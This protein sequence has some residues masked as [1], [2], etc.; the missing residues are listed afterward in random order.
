M[1]KRNIDQ[2]FSSQVSRSEP[3][4]RLNDGARVAVIGGGPAGSFFSYFLLDMAERIRLDVEVDIYEPRDFSRPAPYG[5]N[6]CGGVVSESLVQYLA[7]EGINLPPTVVQRG[8]DSYMMH[9][10]VGSK[11][12]ETPLHEK[13]I[14]A[15]HRGG[16]PR[17]IQTKKWDSFDGYLLNLA[18]EKGAQVLR[19][20]V[21]SVKW[22]NGR[23]HI[24][25]GKEESQAYD[26]V[27]VSSGVNA[28]IFRRLGDTAPHYKPPQT[29]K[30]AIREYHLGME[31]IAE[32]FGSSF[33]V[34]L[35]DLPR[36]EFAAIIPKGDYVTVILL[37]EAIDNEL[38]GSFL[39][40]PP[41][42]NRFPPDWQW[43]DLACNCS[44]RINTRGSAKPYSDRIVFI[45]DCGVTRLYKDGIG[46]AYRTAKAAAATAV[47]EGVSAQDFRQHF[48]RA[49]R[50]IERDNNIGK[51]IF[52]IV[53]LIQKMPFARHGLLRM[54]AKEQ[55]HQDSAKPMSSV[56]WDTFTGS[57]AYLDI[58]MRTLHPRFL[59]S[60]LGHIASVFVQPQ[61][62]SRA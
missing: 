60:F 32:Y 43:E 62:K 55:A 14:A 28:S 50:Q 41:V 49:C 17:S 18:Q 11:R 6:M 2:V 54:V 39:N 38:L 3:G 8:I 44:P 61:Q 58:L 48:G 52:M 53:R 57:A 19:T 1:R 25:V 42:K 16:G 21:N 45:G 59:F 40:S 51:L 15:V 31:R 24:Q 10:D 29:T 20:R 9:M 56:L 22:E 35:L 37:G 27:V 12:I 4:A 34:F 7:A 30:S 5:C 46:A 47:F 33:H 23:P 13:R 26:L 36:L